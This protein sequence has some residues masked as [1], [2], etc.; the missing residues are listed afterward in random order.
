[1][2][3]WGFI[4]RVRSSG[5]LGQRPV[6]HA[7]PRTL[8]ISLQQGG[9]ARTGADLEHKMIPI[10][11]GLLDAQKKARTLLLRQDIIP[12]LYPKMGTA[13]QEGV[14]P[15]T[16]LGPWVSSLSESLPR[17]QPRP[18]LHAVSQ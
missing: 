13:A 8:S 12:A 3:P 7:H 9:R 18:H 5:D 17:P 4:R 1:M 15:L 10:K 6:F 16:D 2:K 14:L 11:V